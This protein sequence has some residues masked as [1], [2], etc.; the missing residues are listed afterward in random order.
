[1]DNFLEHT[2]QNAIQGATMGHAYLLSGSSQ[3]ARET[4]AKDFTMR[5]LCGD[6]TTA[7]A[8]HACSHCTKVDKHIHPDV[9]W[10]TPLEGKREIS[11]AQMRE[12]ITKSHLLPNEAERMVFVISPANALN[13]S[14]QNAFLKTLEEPAGQSVFLLLCENPQALLP[15][16]VSRCISLNLTPEVERLTI[17]EDIEDL[18][19]AFE[20]ARQKGPMALSEFSFTLE[21][22]ER[23]LFVDFITAA[24]PYFMQK[25]VSERGAQY[26]QVVSLFESLQTDLRF[27]V[28]SG[29]MAGKICAFLHN[30]EK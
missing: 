3:Q 7:H 1:M 21:K 10:L 23:T 4:L 2:A 17:G 26:M 9:A 19:F 25:L 13:P 14:A 27:H 30:L 11:V 20:K 5:A 22:L 29:H 15:T 12:L 18:I 6:N 24:Y 16:V 8:C 28:S